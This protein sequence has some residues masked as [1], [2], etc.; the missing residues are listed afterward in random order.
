MD[1]V[2]THCYDC[3][4]I[5]RRLSLRIGASMPYKV[6]STNTTP[7]VEVA[8]SNSKKYQSDT[9]NHVYTHVV[10]NMLNILHPLQPNEL[11]SHGPTVKVSSC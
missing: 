5:L 8:W 10:T 1:N 6:H 11:Q 3:N 9:K 2:T 4:Q 7:T